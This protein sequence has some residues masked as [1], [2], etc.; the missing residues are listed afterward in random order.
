MTRNGS[1]KKRIGIAPPSEYPRVQ[2]NTRSSGRKSPA[3]RFASSRQCEQFGL[4]RVGN[5]FGALIS[6]GA[7]FGSSAVEPKQ[8]ASNA[9]TQNWRTMPP[10]SIANAGSRDRITRVK[11]RDLRRSFDADYHVCGR[12]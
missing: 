5:A 7:L 9:S 11:L 1:M 12:D 4:M 10:I 2:H 3:R 6:R 8:T